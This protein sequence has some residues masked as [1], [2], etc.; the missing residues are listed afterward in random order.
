MIKVNYND[1]NL[2]DGIP[3]A[4]GGATFFY[5]GEPFTGIVQYFYP[6]GELECEEEFIDSHRDGHHIEWYKDGKVREE[7]YERYNNYYGEYKYYYENGIL[8]IHALYNDDS[9]CLWTKR[10][11]EQGKL[12]GHWIK[13]VKVL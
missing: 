9:I 8:E 2:K 1:I 5:K 11:D 4:G 3:D 7:Y 12:V 6:T 10:Y 13:G